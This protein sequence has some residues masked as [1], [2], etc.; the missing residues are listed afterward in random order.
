MADWFRILDE[1][2]VDMARTT[3]VAH[4]RGAMALLRWVNGLPG[5]VRIH[6]II[7]ISCNFDFQP[8]R[9]DGDAFYTS[10]LDYDDLKRKC[11]NLVVIHSEDDSYVPIAAGE[12]LAANLDAKFVRYK[13]AGHFGSDT[14]KAPEILKEI[15]GL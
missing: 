8:N 4:A 2:R 9:T 14:L 3:F 5:D 15:V 12:Q 13:S 10:R 1:L 7:T 6:Q 11:R